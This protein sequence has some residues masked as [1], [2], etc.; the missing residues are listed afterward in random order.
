MNW[1]SFDFLVNF[2]ILS[3]F[4]KHFESFLDTFRYIFCNFQLVLPQ[5]G[6]SLISSFSQFVHSL[7]CLVSVWSQFGLTFV[8]FLSNFGAIFALFCLITTPYYSHFILIQYL[9]KSYHFHIMQ[10][11]VHKVSSK[12]LKLNESSILIS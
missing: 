3:S 9:Y 1:H 7:V 4:L 11:N 5:L 2:V 6:L 10:S 12:C 8:Y